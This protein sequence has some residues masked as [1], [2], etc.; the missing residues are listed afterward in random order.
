MSKSGRYPKCI[1]FFVIPVFF[2]KVKRLK[3]QMRSLI[4]SISQFFHFFLMFYLLLQEEDMKLKDPNLP[5]T[6]DSQ[7][8][9]PGQVISA[10]LTPIQD[11][12]KP[13][14]CGEQ[15]VSSPLTPR[16]QNSSFTSERDLQVTDKDLDNLF[17]SSSSDDSVDDVVNWFF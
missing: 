15:P 4:P 3:C 5:P 6:P 14:S 11:P 7:I 9:T 16:N 8:L 1:N 17:E 12:P 2:L 10:P 13:P